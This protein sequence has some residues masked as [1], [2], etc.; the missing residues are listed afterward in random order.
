MKIKILQA[1]SVSLAAAVAVCCMV[2]PAN[3]AESITSVN[4]TNDGTYLSGVYA[5]CTPELINAGV[6]Q[7][8]RIEIWRGG[9]QLA[10]GEKVRTGD[11]VKLVSG[12]TALQT[13]ELAVSGDVNGDGVVNASDL[14]MTQM[15]ILGL[16]GLGG[17][18]LKA[19]MLSGGSS[20][21]AAD[22]VSMR[23]Y[24]LGIGTP[25]VMDGFYNADGYINAVPV[26]VGNPGL[27]RYDNSSKENIFARNP[28]D[29]IIYNG[30]VFFGSGDYDQNKAPS[31]I[32]CYD[33]KTDKAYVFQDY[34]D[35]EEVSRFRIIDG[36]LISPGID[37]SNN[38]IM[39]YFELNEAGNSFINY[40]MPSD[41][42][43]HN[44]D[45]VEF[46]GKI[47]MGTGTN[48]GR[49]RSAVMVSTDGGKTFSG[50]NAVKDG[51]VVNGTL[52]GGFDR[53]YD[54][55]I[56]S[57]ELY[58]LITHTGTSGYNGIYK[59]NADSNQFEYYGDHS[60]ITAGRNSIYYGKTTGWM[61]YSYVQ[62]SAEFAGKTVICTGELFTTDDMYVYTQLGFGGSSAIYTDMIVKDDTLCF[63][64]ITENDDG[65]FTNAV[66]KTE[67]LKKFTKVLEFTGST[68]MRS[69]EYVSGAFIFGAG[70]RLNDSAS[71]DCGS[72]YRVRVD[73]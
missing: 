68:Y 61:N 54:F 29:M 46:D 4:F 21:S 52:D 64:A 65:T 62:A 6:N 18:S 5:G 2:T 58:A 12:S 38:A 15:S 28:W 34:F 3:A 56:C 27:S 57:G 26:F 45:M 43:M 39:H 73:F 23:Q 16:Y 41:W 20:L 44:F 47:F 19:A 60:I 37:P 69:M 55:F 10:D 25:K 49:N 9:S 33:P 13:L 59:Y 50:V 53:A 71:T 72:I 51:T 36:R 35:D 30:M 8:G 17:S 7:T 63:L 24:V 70:T 11:T 48:A 67:D 14:L 40:A 42:R 32:G 66:Y 31:Y 22:I 1:L